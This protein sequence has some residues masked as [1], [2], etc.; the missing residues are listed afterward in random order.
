MSC[1]KIPYRKIHLDLHTSH[2]IEQIGEEIVSE[3]FADIFTKAHVN[4]INLFAKCH[5][6]MYY[7]PTKIGTMH[8]HL[9][10]DLFGE[11]VRACREK[12]IRPIAYTCAAWNEDWADRHPEWL[13]VD[14][15]GIL[16]HKKPFDRSFGAWRSLCYNNPQYQ[17]VLKEEMKEIYDNY[18]PDGFW[19]DIIQG[20][21]CICPYCSRDMKEYGLDPQ[22]IRD[23]RLFNKISE[24]EFCRR[25]YSYLKGLDSGLCVYFNSHPYE[26]DNGLN[27]YYSSREK[28]QYFDVIDIESLPSDLWGYTHFPVAANYV[29][30]EAKE[31]CMMNGKFHTSWGDFGTIR[32]QNALEYECFRAIACGA[33][34]CIGDQMHPL[35]RLDLAVYDRIGKIYEQI[36]AM[37]PWITG[38]E[39]ICETAVFITAFA[40]EVNPDKGGTVEEGIH[41]IL[42]ELHIPYDF[43][44]CRDDLEK[45]SLLIIP[46]KTRL[47]DTGKIERFLERGGKLLAFADGGLKDGEFMIPQLPA[48]Y[49]G[50][51]EYDVR[52][53][54][55]NQEEFPDIPSMK[56]V[57]YSPGVRIR[58]RGEVLA[59]VTEPYFSRNSEHFCSHRQSPPGI[60]SREEGFAKEA[61]IVKNDSVIYVQ[62]PLSTLYCEYGYGVYRD[63][64]EGCID[65]L[66]PRRL[67]MTDLSGISEVYLR[68]NGE[69]IILHV[70]SYVI[71]RKSKRL[72]TIEDKFTEYKKTIKVRT[73][74]RPEKVTLLTENAGIPV[75]WEDGYTV[76][77]IEAHSGYSVYIIE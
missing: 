55:V 40:G 62:A 46:E 20:Q 15:N 69:K 70:L 25:F 21:D 16:G 3:E 51:S 35:G 66:C 18:H 50:E 9:H 38:D 60:G 68:R 2:Y 36:E 13:V 19:I 75:Q 31:I 6:G 64:V 77:P 74:Q 23:V 27:E 73:D 56:H 59:Q 7:Y 4:S 45:Y 52:Y 49:L 71:T 47:K 17:E 28:R 1:E 5:H 32:N 37:E 26:L 39:K 41:R 29:G 57:L 48:E 43:V 58:A 61:A 8:P 63:I 14:T 53:I 54:E 11:Q 10:F 67:I 72:D 12:G 65:L 24:T 22:D 30:K 33:K 76:I 34:V 42:S 44:D